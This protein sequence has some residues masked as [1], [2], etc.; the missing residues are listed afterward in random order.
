[1]R[2][3]TVE[4]DPMIGAGLKKALKADGYAI[5]WA[6]DGLEAWEALQSQ[7]Y[8]LVLLDLGLPGMDGIT[9]LQKLRAG[10]SDLPVLVIT[11]RDSVRDRVLGLDSGA[12]DY[13]VK[14]F[15]LEELEARIRSLLRRR[16]SSRG[17][18]ISSGEAALDTV[19]K[20]LTYKGKSEVLS[21]KEFALM[22][23]L[24]ATAGSVLTR[25]QLE[26]ALY[27]WNEEIA[28]NAVEVHIHQ[29]RKK[30]GKE[31]IRNIRGLG[32]MVPS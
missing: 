23:V 9:L 4:D 14:P 26:E 16:G 1:M 13:L 22:S 8:D 31:I 5:D 17:S 30:F 18:I 6:K 11:A 10:N 28:S 27:G 3:L 21:A 24:M 7:N 29:L 12:D 20:K 15:S 32:Y 25:A 2:L 19:S